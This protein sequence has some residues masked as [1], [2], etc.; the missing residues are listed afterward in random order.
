MHESEKIKWSHSVV[1][2]SS[3]PHELQPTRLLHPWDFP[4]KSAGVRS[5]CLLRISRLQGSKGSDSFPVTLSFMHSSPSVT[6]HTI[7]SFPCF[8][9][10]WIFSS[11]RMFPQA[12]HIMQHTENGSIFTTHWS[13]QRRLLTTRGGQG[14]FYPKALPCCPKAEMVNVSCNIPSMRSLNNCPLWVS[15][16]I[17]ECFRAAHLTNPMSVNPFSHST[18]PTQFYLS[19]NIYSNNPAIIP[20]FISLPVYSL[21]LLFS[22]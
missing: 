6:L 20:Y 7:L 11:T 12:L 17:C 8:S 4:G 13:K 16:Y 2:D 21:F 18:I 5:H 19:H 1:S 10:T 9:S 22:V 15:T 3:R 14:L